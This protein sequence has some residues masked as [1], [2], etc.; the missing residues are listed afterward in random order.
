MER[1]KKRKR[2][3]RV[4][5]ISLKEFL[6]KKTEGTGTQEEKKEEAEE[7]QDGPPKVTKKYI[8]NKLGIDEKKV[9]KERA[10]DNSQYRI[11]GSW[12]SGDTKQT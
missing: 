1:R 2:K 7:E 5:K 9:S 10:Q 12:K 6:E 11:L 3:R 4:I 8:F